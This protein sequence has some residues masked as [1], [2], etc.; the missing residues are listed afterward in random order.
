[1]LP[2]CMAKG[3][4]LLAAA[5]VWLL[6]LLGLLSGT[7]SNA[8]GPSKIWC[9][10]IRSHSHYYQ[11]LSEPCSQ[12]TDWMLIQM[13]KWYSVFPIALHRGGEQTINW[14]RGISESWLSMLAWRFTSCIRIHLS[15][16]CVIPDN[17]A[18]G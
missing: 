11:S 5:G 1:M 4:G 18:S 3:R 8:W 12:G 14:Q 15:H 2:G 7:E 17:L 10:W 16:R 13:L 6:C 9:G